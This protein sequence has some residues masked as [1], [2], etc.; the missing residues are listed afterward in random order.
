MQVT[1]NPI[2]SDLGNTHIYSSHL[3]RSL[4]VQG[5]VMSSR[6]QVLSVFYPPLSP[7]LVIHFLILVFFVSWPQNGYCSFRYHL[8]LAF[9]SYICDFY[10]ESEILSRSF[11]PS[12]KPV[13]CKGECGYCGLKVTMTHSPKVRRE[14]Y[15]SQ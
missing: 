14:A 5:S 10:Y 12:F 11:K 8:H 13:T 9:A 3:I 2:K 6:I 15:P 1:E 7:S 4:A